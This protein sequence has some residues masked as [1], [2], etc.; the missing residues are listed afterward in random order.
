MLLEN[1]LLSLR[2]WAAFKIHIPA[3]HLVHLQHWGGG[4]QRKL[5]PNLH[6]LYMGCT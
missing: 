4:R 3:R 6:I 5:C 2:Y 1:G